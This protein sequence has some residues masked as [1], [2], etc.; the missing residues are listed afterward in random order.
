MDKETDYLQEKEK[1][2]TPILAV[3]EASRCLLCYD[4][5]CTNAC[6]AG[7][8]PAKFI[9]SL[10]F[11]NF[12]GAASTIRENNVLGG[13]CA[14]VCPTDKYCEGACSRC[15][16]D[17]P[18][19]IGKLQR[20][21]TDY[22]QM[23]GIKSLKAVKAT[24][25]KVAIIG[26]GPSGLSAAAKLALAGYKVTVFEA[27]EQ[28][29]GWLTYG[30]PENRLPQ[31]VVENEIQYVKDL[32]VEFKTNCKVGKGIK[33]ED[34]KKDGFRAFLLATGMQKG[35]GVNIKGNDLKGVINGVDFLA[36]AKTSRGNIEVGKKVVVIGGGD[37]AMDC[38]STV[39]LLGAE[40]VKVVYRRNMEK[41]P[42]DRK[43]LAYIQELNIPVF[44]G[45]KPAEIVGENGR[46]SKFKAVG[47]F[48]NSELNLDAD[49]VIFAVGQEPEKNIVSADVNEKGIFK[50]SKYM[51]N[52][53]G[54]FASGDIAEGD[55]TVVY[56][57]KE[58]KEA[59]DSIIKY[60]TSKKEGVR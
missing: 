9:R 38:A 7:T 54:I 8:D 45:F 58:G 53:D 13:I 17:K 37:V 35:K 4:A 6:P 42:A 51:T 29:G 48:D 59:A 16:I 11:R 57:V 41:M 47:M 5:P 27:R 34:L 52:V 26:S 36:K 25:D 56:A 19:Q 15:G 60:L 55:K 50:T 20:Y 33:I 40:D 30:I 24:K 22:E 49:M 3:E 46:V 1:M 21:L 12:K 39:K 31:Q 18:I 28:L 44:T 10:R 2:F 23:T 43:E 32:G 14:R